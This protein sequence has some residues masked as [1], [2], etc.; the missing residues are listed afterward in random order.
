[1]GTYF[2]DLKIQVSSCLLSSRLKW[3]HRFPEDVDV[4]VWAENEILLAES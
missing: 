3:L 4:D 2:K 1:M